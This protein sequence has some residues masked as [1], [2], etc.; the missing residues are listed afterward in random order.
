M[1]QSCGDGIQVEPESDEFW[2][3]EINACYPRQKADL[4]FPNDRDLYWLAW[5]RFLAEATQR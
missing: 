3:I 1:A 2:F 5:K 4:L